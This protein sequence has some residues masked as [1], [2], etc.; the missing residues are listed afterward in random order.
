MASVSTPQ[1]SSSS[2]R[3]R[4]VNDQE[5]RYT[6]QQNMNGNNLQ[7]NADSFAAEAQQ[8]SQLLSMDQH[9]MSVPDDSTRTAQAALAT[10]MQ[11]SNY[12]EPS[13]YQGTPG[14]QQGY[15]DTPGSAAAQALYDAAG[16]RQGSGSKP[17]VGSDQWHQLRKDNHK[18]G[19]V[20][21]YSSGISANTI[22]QSSVAVEKSSM[23][24]SKISPRL[25]Q[26]SRRIKE[27]FSRGLAST[28]ESFKPRSVN[29]RP[30][31]QRSK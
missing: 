13:S 2:K 21:A 27:R 7:A 26:M 5:G 25:C 15:D 24:A 22:Y 16:Q 17:Q 11:S 10:P 31:E 20:E 29:S 1:L 30:S 19:K 9:V 18:E 23:R 12:P 6:K 3:K 14:M 4:Q 28:L 8:I